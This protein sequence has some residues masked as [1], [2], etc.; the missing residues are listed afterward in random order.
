MYLFSQNDQDTGTTQGPGTASKGGRPTSE[1][2]TP[3]GHTGKA[4]HSGYTPKMIT[5]QTVWMGPQ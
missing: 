3:S 4:L 1:K 2:G 5:K